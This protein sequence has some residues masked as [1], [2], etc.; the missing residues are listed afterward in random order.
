MDRYFEQ[1]HLNWNERAGIHTLDRTGFYD[2]EAFRAGNS[3]LLPLEAA[4]IGDVAGKDL[5]HLQCHFGLDT[6][7]LARLGARVTG[8]DFSEVAIK[9]AR[10]LAGECGLEARFVEGNVYDTR[11]LIEETFDMVYVTWGTICWLPDVAGWA[12]IVAASLKPGGEFYFADAHPNIQMLEE[13]NGELVVRYAADTPV[14]QPLNFAEPITYTGDDTPLANPDCHEWNHSLGTLFSGLTGAG[15]EIT[16]LNEHQELP[17]PQ[18]PMMVEAGK[19]LFRLPDGVPRIPLA[20]S[21]KARK[22]I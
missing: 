1:N 6:L 9:A 12:E 13:E 14:D 8:L 5:L 20:L 10:E 11:R 22:N 19:G 17:W 4:E 21:L 15:L 18:F 7:S 2:L 16:M 3:V